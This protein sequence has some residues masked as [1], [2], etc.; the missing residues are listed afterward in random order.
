[1]QKIM[2]QQLHFWGGIIL[3]MKMKDMKEGIYKE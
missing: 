1:M 3:N 2:T